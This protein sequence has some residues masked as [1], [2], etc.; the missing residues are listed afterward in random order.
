TGGAN[1][2]FWNGVEIGRDE[3]YRSPF[4]DRDVYA[5]GAHAGENRLAVKVCV[6]RRAWGL[7]ARLTLP[8]GNRVEGLEIDATRLA[9]GPS[10]HGVDGLTTP[11]SDFKALFEA[12][13]Q[14]GAQP[15]ALEN[16]AR[17][18]SMT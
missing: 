5:V 4:M 16:L 12:A 15:A 10:G 11:R 13:H 18:L 17:F 14:D 1:R 3:T 8:D 7:F 6:E 2:V 9:A